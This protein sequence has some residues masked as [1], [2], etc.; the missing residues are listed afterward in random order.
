[1]C[2]QSPL[3]KV[4][5]THLVISSMVAPLSV[6]NIESFDVSLP[7]VPKNCLRIV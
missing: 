2:A 4:V 6:A 5:S 7:S 3:L 1:M